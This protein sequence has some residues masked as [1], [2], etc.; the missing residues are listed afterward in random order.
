[1][2]ERAI[3]LLAIIACAALA[4]GQPLEVPFAETAP[5]KV[6]VGLET[7]PPPAEDAG[8][9]P[10]DPKIEAVGQF[11]DDAEAE[12]GS[13]PDSAA[14]PPPD[15]FSPAAA[16]LNALMALCAVLALFLFLVYLGK[17]FGKRTPFLAGGQLGQIMGRV[18]LS[19]QAALHFVRTNGEV[20]VIG[21]TQNS[22]NLLRSYDA[23]EFDA[24]HAGAGEN[25]QPAA[26]ENSFVEQLK[27]AQHAMAGVPGVDEDLDTLKGDLQRLQKYIQD[28]ARARE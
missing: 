13:A 15:E 11:W 22:V 5:P 18:A 25:A 8:A 1:M 20:L 9:V 23:V 16:M 12:A 14:V 26:P 21:V 2:P 7:A 17:R 24:A 4:P 19:P 3:A 10:I 27:H 6:N 28:S